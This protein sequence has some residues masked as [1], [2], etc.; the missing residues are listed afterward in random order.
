MGSKNRWRI[1]TGDY[2]VLYKIDDN[3][4]IVTVFRVVHRREAYR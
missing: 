3:T 4:R 2:R 1:R